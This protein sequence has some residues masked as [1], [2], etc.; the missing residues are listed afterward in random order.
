MKALLVMLVLGI[1]TFI[2]VGIPYFTQEYFTLNAFSFFMVVL[3]SIILGMG[4]LISIGDSKWMNKLF[5]KL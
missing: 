2:M 4:F 5:E 1:S 3:G